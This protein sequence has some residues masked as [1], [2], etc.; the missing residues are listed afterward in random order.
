MK[1]ICKNF[2]NKKGKINLYN[3]HDL[4]NLLKLK[5][6]IEQEDPSLFLKYRDLSLKQET[7]KYLCK[8]GDNVIDVLCK[9][10]PVHCRH[11]LDKL[12][13]SRGKGK[14]DPW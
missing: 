3:I 1:R 13:V 7:F 8:E 6:V 11:D 10:L 5:Y 14:V 12:V 2:V 9:V 4:L